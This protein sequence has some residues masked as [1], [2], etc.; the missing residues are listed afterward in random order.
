MTTEETPDG[1]V[2]GVSM[3]HYLDKDRKIV[4][5]GR[6]EGDKLIVRTPTDPQGKAVPWNDGVIGYYGQEL[7]FVTHKAKTGDRFEAVS[8][9]NCRS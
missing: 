1:K 7:L 8:T 9:T 3:T 4:Q 5:S 2:V 6:V